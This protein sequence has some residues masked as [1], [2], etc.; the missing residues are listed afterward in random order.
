MVQAELVQARER[1]EGARWKGGSR[2][3]PSADKEVKTGQF[4]LEWSPALVDTTNG[5]YQY[6]EVS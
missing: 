1:R 5:A 6:I 2:G 3:T 4:N